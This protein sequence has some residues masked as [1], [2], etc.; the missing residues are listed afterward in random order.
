MFPG[1]PEGNYPPLIMGMGSE[2]CPIRPPIHACS[3]KTKTCRV[4]RVQSTRGIVHD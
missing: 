1:S 4:G 2:H 3:R